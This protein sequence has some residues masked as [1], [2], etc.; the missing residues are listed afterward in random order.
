MNLFILLSMKQI[1]IDDITD[2][3]VWKKANPNYGI[4]LR[5]EYMKRESKRAMLMFLHIKTLS[6]D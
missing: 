2:E 1:Q 4:S 3:E 6:K 5:K